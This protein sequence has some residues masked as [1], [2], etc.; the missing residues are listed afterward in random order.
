VGPEE[1]IGT[2]EEMETHQDDPTTDEREDP[3]DTVTSEFSGLGQRLRD[4]YR[5]VAD[6]RGPTEDEIR[7]A[8]ATLAGAWNQV[9]ESVGAALKDNEVREH[10]KAAASAFATAVGSTITEL[11][12]ELRKEEEA[13]EEE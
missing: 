12:S 10:L 9:A 4:T 1:L 13:T 11:G 3:W 8:F 2:I 5:S 6:E 7:D